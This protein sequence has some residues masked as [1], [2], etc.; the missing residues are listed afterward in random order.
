MYLLKRQGKLDKLITL[1][2]S[3]HKIHNETDTIVDAVKIGDNI[4][5]ACVV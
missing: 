3:D 5:E 4:Y 2:D 1:N